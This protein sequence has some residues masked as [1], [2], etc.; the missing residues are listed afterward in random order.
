[1]H[2]QT[3]DTIGEITLGR[4]LGRGAFGTVFLTTLSDGSEYAVKCLDRDSIDDNPICQNLFETEISVMREIKH[5]N[6]LHLYQVL[7]DEEGYYLLIQYCNGGDLRRY[8]RRQPNKRL[9]EDKALFFLKQIICGFQELHD[10]GVM[11]RDFKLANVFLHDETVVIGDFGLAKSGLASTGTKVGTQKN[12][13]PE[14]LKKFVNPETES[15]AYSSKVDIWAIGCS[16]YEMIFGE[17]PFYDTSPFEM[18][19]TIKKISGNNLKFPFSVSPQSEDLLRGMLQ[20][21]PKKRFGWDDVFSDPLFDRPSVIKG[22]KRDR[23]QEI[24]DDQFETLKKT[25]VKDI[26]LEDPIKLLGGVAKK[27]KKDAK[28]QDKKNKLDLKSF[29]KNNYQNYVLEHQESFAKAY[30]MYAQDMI[31]SGGPGQQKTDFSG[32]IPSKNSPFS[33]GGQNSSYNPAIHQNG[34][35]FGPGGFSQGFGPGI[36][37]PFQGYQ[38]PPAYNGGIPP[39]GF[40]MP[41]HPSQ[42]FGGGPA[43][44]GFN[45]FGG[46]QPQQGFGGFPQPQG[47]SSVPGQNPNQFGNGWASNANQSPGGSGFRMNQNNQNNQFLEFLGRQGGGK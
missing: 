6:I 10:K 15:E 4:K 18:L 9:T 35:G 34:S 22:S 32:N 40:S 2:R 36:G 46:P 21:D 37:V 28:E 7:E 45:A 14:L 20:A 8:C 39:Q 29:K 19:E 33:Q 16:Y 17:S 42:G 44:P 41:P 31:D 47:F 13:A 26:K 5:P 1:M 3:G 30:A 38:P 11:H 43:P 25:H 23:T 12:M 27:L 24:V